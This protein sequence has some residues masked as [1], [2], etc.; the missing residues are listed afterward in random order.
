MLGNKE[1]WGEFKWKSTDQGAATHVYAAFAP[2][3]KG[4]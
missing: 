1:A 4:M 2:A 3:L